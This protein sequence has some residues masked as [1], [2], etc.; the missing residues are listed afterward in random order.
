MWLPGYLV[1]PDPDNPITV[2]TR[3]LKSFKTLEWKLSLFSTSGDLLSVSAEVLSHRRFPQ[4]SLNSPLADALFCFRCRTTIFFVLGI[5]L[6]LTD[7]HRVW[8]GHVFI[9]IANAK[10]LPYPG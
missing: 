10:E 9:N 7:W 2:A 5:F 6:S 4:M 8:M 1:L 3:R